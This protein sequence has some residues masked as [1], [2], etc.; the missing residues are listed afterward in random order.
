PRMQTRPSLPGGL[1]G[2]F[3]T[4]MVCENST[5]MSYTDRTHIPSAVKK[6]QASFV[7]SCCTTTTF[8]THLRP[9][10]AQQPPELPTNK[11]SRSRLSAVTCLILSPP[12]KA[13]L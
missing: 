1:R 12:E 5:L 2:V 11:M 3:S 7:A 6:L 8:V 9:I 4:P 13:W 10:T